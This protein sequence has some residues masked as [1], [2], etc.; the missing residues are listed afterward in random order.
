M[1]TQ[2]HQRLPRGGFFPA[3]WDSGC[4]YKHNTVSRTSRRLS[5]QKFLSSFFF[6]FAYRAA[7]RHVQHTVRPVR[8]EFHQNRADQFG[9]VS[10]SPKVVVSMYSC[11]WKSAWNPLRQKPPLIFSPPVL[12]S[13]PACGYLLIPLLHLSCPSSPPPSVSSFDRQRWRWKDSV[14]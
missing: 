14:T 4:T 3:V 7:E 1:S 12:L 2:V 10:A 11:H 5:P 8:A 6:F 9:F 13:C